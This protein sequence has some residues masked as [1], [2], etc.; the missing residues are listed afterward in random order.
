MAAGW[1]VTKHSVT[2]HY[3]SAG[4]GI[5]QYVMHPNESPSAISSRVQNTR[6]GKSDIITKWGE[7]LNNVSKEETGVT[8][9]LKITE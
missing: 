8:S 7:V 5:V 4:T 1:A 2:V 9:D 6:K 3:T